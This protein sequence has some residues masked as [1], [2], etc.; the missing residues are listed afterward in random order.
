[1]SEQTEP[2][3]ETGLRNKVLFLIHGRKQK[4]LKDDLEK[5]WLEALEHGI[6]REFGSS[7]AQLTSFKNVSKQFIYYG[8][9]SNDFFEKRK[10]SYHGLDD[11]LARW[12]TLKKLKGY[13]SRD[14]SEATYRSIRAKWHPLRTGVYSTL[15]GLALMAPTYLMRFFMLDIYHYWK[16][17]PPFG[18]GVGNL[19]KRALI[20]ALQDGNQDILV[21]AH[22]LGSIL[23]YDVMAEASKASGIEGRLSV[24]ATIGSPLGIRYMQRHLRHWKDYPNN[25]GCWHNFSAKDD[26]VS[27]DREIA[28]DFR[29]MDGARYDHTEIFN[30]AVKEGKA[31]QHQATGYLIHPCM[32]R[33]VGD[34]VTA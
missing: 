6:T 11:T 34:W 23:V 1:M 15:A 24:F 32:A 13:Q 2:D 17:K 5:L 22:S 16:K 8:D 26:Y 10:K 29:G 18:K 25:I 12:E 7:S 3:N 27:L 31:H 28:D 33:L 14:F 20:S 9:L 19:T 30:L 4:P 21:I